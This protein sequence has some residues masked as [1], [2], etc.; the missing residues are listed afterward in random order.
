MVNGKRFE[1][2]NSKIGEHATHS[3][4]KAVL[5]TCSDLF[6]PVQTFSHLFSPVHTCSQ[7]FT[8]IHTFSDLF[9]PVHTCS[10]LFLPVHT[11]S[12]L[13]DYLYSSLNDSFSLNFPLGKAVIFEQV[14]TGVKRF[15]QVWTSQNRCEVLSFPEGVARYPNFAY[16]ST[17][18]PH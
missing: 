5:H 14:W 9:T 10:H 13:S 8:T 7:L 2:R 11:C 12:H 4:G 16:L 1:R 18:L 6:K 17:E 3:L 15:G